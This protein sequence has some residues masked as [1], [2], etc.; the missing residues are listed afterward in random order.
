MASRSSSVM[1][2]CEAWSRGLISLCLGLPICKMGILVLPTS[3]NIQ[4]LISVKQLTHGTVFKGL[5]RK[6]MW[7]LNPISSFPSQLTLHDILFL[8]SAFSFVKWVWKHLLHGLAGKVTWDNVCT[9]YR[10]SVSHY[11]WWW[12]QKRTGVNMQGSWW[13]KRKGSW[14]LSV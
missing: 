8:T 3:Y 6:R 7:C 4:E 10:Y 13:F 12:F 2:T 11:L 14:S 5:Q 9:D 1:P